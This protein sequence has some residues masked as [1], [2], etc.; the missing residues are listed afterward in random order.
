MQPKKVA[1]FISGRGSNAQA[2]IEQQNNKAYQVVL[3][4]G[5]H[6]KSEIPN[7]CLK[8]SVPFVSVNK[9]HFFNEDF[10]LKTLEEFQI[11]LICLAGFLWKIPTF[12]TQKYPNKILNIH[13][14]LLPK[15]GGKG[16][17]GIKIHEAV[18]A[19]QEKES[20]VTIHW[21]NEDY[22]KGEI[23]FQAKIFIDKNDTPQRLADKILALEHQSYTQ[24]LESVCK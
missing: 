5:S 22:D 19:N 1:I 12:L 11:E 2:L 4:L 7:F 16:M 13:P 3:V 21:V 18:I 20:G 9:D 10:L 14:S 8:H 17:Y 6:E 23:L 15:Y 24:V